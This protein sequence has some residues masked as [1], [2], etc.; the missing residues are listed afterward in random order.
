VICWKSRPVAPEGVLIDP[1]SA[2]PADEPEYPANPSADGV[3]ALRTRRTVRCRRRRLEGQ[4]V[5]DAE[6]PQYL[7]LDRADVAPALVMKQPG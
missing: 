3:P 7:P 4:E 1:D 2:V 6:H 5:G